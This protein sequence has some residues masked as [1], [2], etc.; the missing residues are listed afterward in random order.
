MMG[1]LAILMLASLLL[2]F[3]SPWVFAIY[4]LIMLVLLAWIVLLALADMVAS[5]QH[6]AHA[7]TKN[8]AEQARLKAEIYRL[9]E[10]AKGDR[11]TGNGKAHK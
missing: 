8:L 11:S 10:E 5:R 4:I 3:M 2:E 9:Q 6:F 1:V 7:Q